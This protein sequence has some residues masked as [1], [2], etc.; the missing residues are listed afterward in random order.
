MLEGISVRPCPR[1]QAYVVRCRL[2]VDKRGIWSKVYAEYDAHLRPGLKKI[3]KLMKKRG[4][5][6]EAVKMYD[7]KSEDVMRTQGHS[8]AACL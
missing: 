5:A 1:S 8:L 3:L 4:S 2:E 6:V 7:P